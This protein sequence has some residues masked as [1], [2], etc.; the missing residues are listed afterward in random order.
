[1]QRRTDR[2]LPCCLCPAATT[3]AATSTAATT[4][5]GKRASVTM[6][7]RHPRCSSTRAWTCRRTAAS[8]FTMAM[9]QDTP[10]ITSRWCRSLSSWTLQRQG[11]GPAAQGT[12]SC[13]SGSSSRQGQSP[14]WRGLDP[15]RKGIRAGGGRGPSQHRKIVYTAQTRS[16]IRDQKRRPRRWVST[17]CNP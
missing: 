9:A 13:G 12:T 10:R 4:T 1:M 11:T 8:T 2:L 17:Q 14:C 6:T 3:G 7:R 16:V 15:L 5:G